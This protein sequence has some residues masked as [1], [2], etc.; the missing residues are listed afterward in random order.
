L[1]APHTYDKRRKHNFLINAQPEAFTMLDQQ[2]KLLHHENE[3][4]ITHFLTATFKNQITGQDKTELFSC[5][6]TEPLTC[7]GFPEFNPQNPIEFSGFL[8][9]LLDVFRQPNISIKT[10]T[11]EDTKVLINFQIQG[12]HHEEFMGL[13]ASNGLLLLNTD[14]LFKFY[15][16]RISEIWMYNKKVTLS[17]TNGN[18]YE[19]TNRQD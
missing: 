2:E 10:I 16:N 19:L 18:I 11:A 15:K 6:L 7:R 5:T 17:T 8:N 4:L 12:D 9:Y 3:A 13:A 14:I 1:H